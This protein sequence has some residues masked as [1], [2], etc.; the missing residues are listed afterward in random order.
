[1]IPFLLLLIIIL[2]SLNIYFYTQL[3][4]SNFNIKK[5][6]IR[7]DHL[8][9]RIQDDSSSEE[10]HRAE[11][12]LD[13]YK[14]IFQKYI[15][16]FINIKTDLAVDNLEVVDLTKKLEKAN[17]ELVDHFTKILTN[18]DILINQVEDVT[19]K[20]EVK[21]LS[22]VSE[23]NKNI[24]FKFSNNDGDIQNEEFLVYIQ[25]KYNALLKQIIDELVITHKRKL[26][27]IGTLDEIYKKV[28]GILTFSDEISEIANGI[29]LISLN[30]NIEA[31]HAGNAGKGFAVVAN[32]IRR[33]ANESQNAAV[34]VKKEIKNTN[35]FIRNSINTIK[36]AMDVESKY[37]NSTI[38][39]IQD[40]F[41]AMTQTLFQ[42]IF[43]LTVTLMKSMGKTSSVKNEI[44]QVINTMQIDTYI[45]EL[46]NEIKRSLDTIIN[47]IHSLGVETLSELENT[48]AFDKEFI[49]KI[50]QKL[51]TDPGEIESLYSNKKKN[52]ED[53]I[54]FF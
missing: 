28:N 2:I 9:H 39:I 46:N 14:N 4:K 38:A 26:E 6:H 3:K 49:E 27:D 17:L 50:K 16:E 18:I 31:A 51:E 52:Q 22:F 19:D 54:T 34:R 11:H 53:D 36:E 1:M 15:S 30:A 29:E 45:A 20:A 5:S 8:K 12:Y 32:E 35:E 42:L 43:E 41:M 13:V 21:L 33:L 48:S 23:E 24:D 7:V 25:K 37:L 44:N 47:N 40:V 10:L